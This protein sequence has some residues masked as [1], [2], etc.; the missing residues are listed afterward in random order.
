VTEANGDSRVDTTN[1]GLLPR[2]L[3]PEG[4]TPLVFQGNLPHGAGPQDSCLSWSQTANQN[5]TRGGICSTVHEELA[6]MKIKY[7]QPV[8]FSGRK[9]AK[10]Q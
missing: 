8:K 4:S 2:P 1:P 6:A 7:S 10:S 5:E 9:I 3:H